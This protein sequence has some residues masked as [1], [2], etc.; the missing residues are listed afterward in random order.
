MIPSWLNRTSLLFGDVSSGKVCLADW[1]TFFTI[2]MTFAIVELQKSRESEFMNL[3]YHLSKLT[4]IVMDYRTNDM[5]IQKYLF[6]L[7]TYR[8]NLNKN[9]PHL[10]PTINHHNAFHLPKKL[11]SFGSSNY[12]AS[13]HFEQINSILQ[14]TPTNKNISK[15]FHF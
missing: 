4:K 2:F 1:A 6:H 10:N 8:S 5:Q 13:W 14:K 9:H 12:L 11:S 3:W 15:F 7:T